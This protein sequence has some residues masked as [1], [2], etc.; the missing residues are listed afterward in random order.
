VLI[1]GANSRFVGNPEVDRI[2][3]PDVLCV[4]YIY[5]TALDSQRIHN[6]ARLALAIETIEE[7]GKRY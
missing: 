7:V 5:M 4:Y 1:K 6:R 2:R 3:A